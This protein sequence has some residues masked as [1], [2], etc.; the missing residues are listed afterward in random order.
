M[1]ELVEYSDELKD[2]VFRFTSECFTELGKEFEPE[3]R[4]GF[5]KRISSYF[6]GF[7]WLVDSG[8]VVGT[9][10]ISRLDESTCELNSLYVDSSYR[11]QGLGFKLFDHAV[12][13]ARSSGF[14]RVVLDSMS[15][16]ES[17][18]RLYR[19]YGFTD[20]DRYNDNVYAD[21]FMEMKLTNI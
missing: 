9:V 12:V 8:R 6:A 17:A 14:D 4:H 21:V 13:F 11:G 19:R 3:G 5:Y 15:K 10:A 2:E 20:T 7:W 18:G 16:Y 1:I